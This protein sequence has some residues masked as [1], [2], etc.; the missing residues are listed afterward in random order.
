[1]GV[2]VDENKSVVLNASGAGS[3]RLGPY[4][5]AQR[6]HITGASVKVSSNT[7]EPAANLYKGSRGSFLA[8]TYTGSN[9]STDLD[10]ILDNGVILCEWTGGDAGATATLYLRGETL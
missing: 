4:S 2:P 3:V 9:D 8:G 7:S 1:V 10:V 5:L 6:W